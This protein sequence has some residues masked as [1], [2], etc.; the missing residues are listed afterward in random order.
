MVP[1]ADWPARSS[2]RALIDH[3]IAG[4]TPIPAGALVFRIDNLTSRE[5]G[6]TRAKAPHPG[7]RS[8]RRTRVEAVY[9]GAVEDEPGGDG[10]MQERWSN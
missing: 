9:K 4:M 7:S 10:S 3:E 2:D 8:C 5:S 6:V 1:I